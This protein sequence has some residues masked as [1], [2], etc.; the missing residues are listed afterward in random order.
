MQPNVFTVQ[1]SLPAAVSAEIDRSVQQFRSR[2]Q[3]Y[4]SAILI[5]AESNGWIEAYRSELVR[6]AE[7]ARRTQ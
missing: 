1:D 4:G 2:F 5:M 6:I 7:L 3:V